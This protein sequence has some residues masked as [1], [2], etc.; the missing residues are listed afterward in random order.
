MPLPLSLA[1]PVPCAP[2]SL[3]HRWEK[4]WGSPNACISQGDSGSA[5]VPSSSAF[6]QPEPEA[7]T[8]HEWFWGSLCTQISL[9][10]RRGKG[11]PKTHLCKIQIS[12]ALTAIL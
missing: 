7:E 3:Q 1:E 10:G 9:S 4:L 12:T 5:Q 2:N 11:S 6:S 8:R